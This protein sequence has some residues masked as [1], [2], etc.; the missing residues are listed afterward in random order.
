MKDRMAHTVILGAG[1][2]GLAA[3]WKL[4]RAGHPVTVL[5][6]ESVIGGLARTFA[7]GDFRFD[8]GP[9]AFNIDVPEVI[10]E[11]KTLL[12][13]DF[14][15]KVFQSKVVFRN[16]FVNYPLR[17]ADV[18]TSINPLL[19]AYCVVDFAIARI[20][21]RLS[22]KEEADT[23]ESWVV[24]RFGRT[25]YNIYFGPYTKKL[26]GRDPSELSGVFA[27]Q[28]IPVL[29]LWDLIQKTF[30][31][32]QSAP[33]RHNEYVDEAYYPRKGIGQIAERLGEEIVS[34]GGKILT[35]V[36]VLGVRVDG[37]R[38]RSVR[39]RRGGQPEEQACDFLIS[40]IPVR[41]FV[42][43]FT[44]TFGA[45]TSIE[46]GSRAPGAR[47]LGPGPPADVLEAAAGM[48][49][50]SARLMYLLVDREQVSGTP[51]IYFSNPEVLFNRIYEIRCFSPD[52]TPAGKTAICAEITCDEGDPTWRATDDEL[53]PEVIGPLETAGLVRREEVFDYFT[54][55]L[56]FAYPIYET[57]FQ[58]RMKK[59]TDWLRALPNTLIYGRQGLFTYTNTNHSIDMG[60]R[61]A[62]Y[63]DALFTG[64]TPAKPRSE[65][66]LDYTIWY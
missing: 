44:G 17:G 15:E 18:F 61:A 9:H 56:R 1:P 53:Y 26:W 10:E 21:H 30:L 48:H 59:V 66:Y 27:S 8:Y 7:Y 11:M 65:M 2:G 58:H 60:F 25:L 62:A 19:G 33:H 50:R 31:G 35:D 14:V 5:E 40:T 51:Y 24:N 63:A 32:K 47:D 46:L 57:G 41:D 12:G 45:G 54:R 29:H 55:S 3:A 13:S 37:G 39:F 34:Q 42:P 64:R 49:Y 16:K 38:V 20:R 43:L 52:M 28:R 23:F 36:E 4:T 6:R 22:G